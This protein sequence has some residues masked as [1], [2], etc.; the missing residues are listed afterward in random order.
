MAGYGAGYLQDMSFLE[1]DVW[2]RVRHVAF[3]H[4][5]YSCRKYPASHPFP[6]SRRGAEHLGQV[7]DQFSVGRA[8]DIDVLNR[9]PVN[10]D[11]VPRTA[12]SDLPAPVASTRRRTGSR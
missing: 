11:C 12:P 5:S 2:P 8:D 10:A 7:H 1:R 4:D 6:V 3:C 9:T